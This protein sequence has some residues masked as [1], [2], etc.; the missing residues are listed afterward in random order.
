MTPRRA[1]FLTARRE[2]L[3]R[4][5]SRAFVIST[6]IQV[7]V[8]VVIVIVSAVTGGGGT[9]TF[10]VGYAGADAKAVITA[11]GEQAGAVDAKIE[12]REYPTEAAAR[13]AVDG[14]DVD[15]AVSAGTLIVRT[16]ASDTLTSLLQSGQRTVA[17]STQLHSA[18]LSESEIQRALNPPSLDVEEVGNAGGG[19]IAFVGSL[20]L[21]IAIL[22]FGVVVAT[23]V[24]TE[25]SSRVVEVILAAIRPVQLLA[26]KVL[27]IGLIGI[28]QVT[29]I[30]GVGLGAALATN[31]ID[32]P[33]STPE[34]AI[35]VVVYF[36]FGYLLYA[37][38]FAVAGSI[39]SRQEDV[40]SSSA[41]L[42][43]MLVA[44]YL[45]SISTIDSPDSGLATF[46]TFFPPLAPMV[47]P[48]RAAQDALPAWQLAISLILMV[49]ATAALLWMAARI[50]DRVVLRMGAPLKLRQALRFVRREPAG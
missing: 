20:L 46:A 47:V 43:I 12:P 35:L 5:R 30:A 17:A 19:G 34:A 3:E 24:V 14:K 37:S 23:A 2:V 27:G 32:L 29:L 41:P 28:L 36:V 6:L 22:T 33:S 31:T 1:V 16:D 48:G 8:V 13:D 42:T 11:A 21:Y 45:V 50:Y 49:L 9:D 38:A 39:V 40:Q 7:G 18:G 44:G 10:D 26:G 25:K 15:A 4:V